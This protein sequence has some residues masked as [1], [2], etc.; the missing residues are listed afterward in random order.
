MM[1]ELR[2][3][4]EHDFM[5]R[6]RFE[7]KFTHS[8]AIVQLKDAEIASLKDK[9]GKAE[10]KAVAVAGLHKKNAELSGTISGLELVYDG[11]KNMVAKL[12]VDC[13]SLCGEVA[14]DTK[15]REEFASM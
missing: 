9:L 8:S 3:R 14:G 4:Y 13:E 2:L 5:V 6:E 11:L 7:Q 10:S 15:M 12:E 1:F